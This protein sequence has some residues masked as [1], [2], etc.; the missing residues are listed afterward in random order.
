M[1]YFESEAS[2]SA[3]KESVDKILAT[4]IDQQANPKTRLNGLAIGLTNEKETVYVNTA[5]VL[6]AKTGKPFTPS[7]VFNFWSTTKPI[8]VTAILQLYDK[9]LL[10]LD[11]PAEKYLPEVADFKIIT[12]WSDDNKPILKATK[13]KITTRQLITHTAGLSYEFFNDHYA[14]SKDLVGQPNILKITEDTF[15]NIYLLFEPGTDN[16]YGYN[17]DIAG[18]ILE[19]ITGQKLGDY[20]KENI[21]IPAGL[22]TAT[23]KVDPN[24]EDNVL[25]LELRQSDGSLIPSDVQPDQRAD[26]HMGGHGIFGTVE[27]Y[28]GFIRIWLNE[29]KTPDGKTIISH[30]VWQEAISNNLPD[31]VTFSDFPSHDPV[32]TTPIFFD[33]SRLDS[34]GLGFAISEY[35]T[36]T[37][38]PKGTIYWS[39]LANLFFWIDLKNKIGG[40]YASQVLPYCEGSAANYI[41]YETTVY[42]NLSE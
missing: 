38:R 28:L 22:K 19:K 41:N 27:D 12:G 4:A 10:D 2:R 18:F 21:F 20:I 3:I 1:T 35:D 15:K 16:A 30:K 11:V 39:G 25:V 13:N 17:I 23:F 31:G 32:L 14:K 26:I 33:K 8:A 36:P 6:N 24:Q 5:G 42:K 40:Y 37:G 7:T 34:W 29:G 9:G